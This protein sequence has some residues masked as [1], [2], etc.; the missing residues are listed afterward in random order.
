MGA[1]CF[2]SFPM[3]GGGSSWFASG[4]GCVLVSCTCYLR[5]AA[6]TDSPFCW[7]GDGDGLEARRKANVSLLS[8]QSVEKCLPRAHTVSFIRGQSI[9]IFLLFLFFFF[10]CFMWSSRYSHTLKKTKKTGAW[11]AGFRTPVVRCG[12]APV[13]NN[14]TSAQSS[15]VY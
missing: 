9:S 5:K 1:V 10:V 14:A 2:W 15:Y 12:N 6:I 3:L 4:T 7:D 11:E 8:F 13:N